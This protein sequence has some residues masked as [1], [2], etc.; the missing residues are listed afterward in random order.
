M[1]RGVLSVSRC[2]SDTDLVDYWLTG[3]SRELL[4]GLTI[5]LLYVGEYVQASPLT[6]MTKEVQDRKRGRGQK[7]ALHRLAETLVTQVLD[8][9]L[10]VKRCS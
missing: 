3:G 1:V 5:P 4:G 9:C 2:G 8:V 10:V 6:L 7:A